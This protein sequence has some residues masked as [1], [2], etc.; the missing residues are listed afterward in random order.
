MCLSTTGNAM[1]AT[2]GR[3]LEDIR[4]QAGGPGSTMLL[5]TL[6][7]R[8]LQQGLHLTDLPPT[9]MI[10]LAEHPEEQAA[11]KQYS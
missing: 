7:Q 2:L 8:L 9:G 5:S 4:R 11:L 10:F 3:V 1:S 6:G